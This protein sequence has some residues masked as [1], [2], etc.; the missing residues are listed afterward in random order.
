MTKTDSLHRAL[1]VFPA[2]DLDEAMAFDQWLN[3]NLSVVTTFVPVDVSSALREQF[4]DEY[5]TPLWKNGLVP[6]VTLEPWAMEE[7]ASSKLLSGSDNLDENFRDWATQF[8]KWLRSSSQ[9]RLILRPAH[10]MNGSWYPWSVGAGVDPSDYRRV[11]RTIYDIFG[12]ND[13]LKENIQW[14]WSINAET[15]SDVDIAAIYPGD[16]Y[17]DL[18]GVD[19]YNFGGS[20][21]WSEWRGPTS[22]FEPAFKEIR[23]IS[24]APITVP[25]F[26]CS[27]LRDGNID[28]TA[29][30]SW[31][32][33]AFDLF[34]RWDIRLASWFNVDKETD[35]RV[36][37][38]ASNADKRYPGHVVINGTKFAVYPSFRRA[39][40]QYL[41]YESIT[42]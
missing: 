41:A 14:L 27:S 21:D 13:L 35:W 42:L 8:A 36:F 10:E 12:D 31:I 40:I 23:E 6:V 25:E 9:R 1:G 38:I 30:A 16:A 39:A 15:T 4:F 20:Q 28:P 5:L 3:E 37:H 24:E 7:I 22:I 32:L 34:N 2:D 11:W 17:V 33:H 18:I 26:G 29:K 19:G